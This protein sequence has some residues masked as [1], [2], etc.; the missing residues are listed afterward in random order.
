MED[1]RNDTQNEGNK[2]IIFGRIKKRGFMIFRV[3]GTPKV[4]LG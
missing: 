4:G 2:A 1:N 3:H